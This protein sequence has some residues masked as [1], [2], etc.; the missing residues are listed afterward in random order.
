MNL[1]LNL[2]EQIQVYFEAFKDFKSFDF[3][4]YKEL[5]KALAL[6]SK[7]FDIEEKVWRA[8]I[9]VP[10]DTAVTQLQMVQDTN[11]ILE[12]WRTHYEREIVHLQLAKVE[13]ESKNR[14][15]IEESH[16][17]ILAVSRKANATNC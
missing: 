17:Q 12:Q 10:R 3:K 15:E 14:H 8:L 7:Q 1:F 2:K 4:E 16:K 11:A 6:L 13:L 9:F 5:Q